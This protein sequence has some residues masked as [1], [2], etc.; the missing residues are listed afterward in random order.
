MT[1]LVESFPPRKG[2]RMRARLLGLASISL[3]LVVGPPGCS[4]GVELARKDAG[5]GGSTGGRGGSTGGRGGGTGGVSTGG[6]LA[7]GG[8]FPDASA[9]NT[10][11]V[12][13]DAA[14]MADRPV[15]APPPVRMDAPAAD[16]PGADAPAV[17]APAADAPVPDAR[18]DTAPDVAPD[19]PAAVD[20]APTG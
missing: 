9:P 17:D 1:S 15:D 16:R 10:G 3:W 19:A 13:L 8:A 4:G 7:T 2:A 5:A 12:R 20:S 14:P 6:A 18:V 11:G